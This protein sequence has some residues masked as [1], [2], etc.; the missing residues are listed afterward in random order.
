MPR[1]IFPGIT[2]TYT[3]A[4][5]IF[6]T[7][8]TMYCS[9]WVVPAGVTCLTFEIWGA[10][11]AGAPMCCCT[12]YGG[13]AGGGGAYSM[14]TLAVTPGD[15]YAFVVGCGGCGSS[16]WYQANACG[17]CGSKTYITGNGLSNFCALGGKGGVWCNTSPCNCCMQCDGIDAYG[18]DLNL[19]GFPQRFTGH[20]S[21]YAACQYF[22]TGSAP[23][24]GGFH[25]TSGAGS[26]SSE[27]S[28]GSH[29]VYPGGGGTQRPM[30]YPGW[31]DCCAGCN[32]GGSDGL[33]VITL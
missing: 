33:I 9:P 23:M 25:V 20:S 24:G 32:G 3:G 16:Q 12:C 8:H 28:C 1:Y 29:G 31:C 5:K 15:S 4:K 13:T 30:Y 21:W 27:I 2:F 10:G 14:K 11:G 22:F 17:C 6:L 26:C 18:G 7:P 19:T